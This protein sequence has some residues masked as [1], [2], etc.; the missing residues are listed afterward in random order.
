MK[1]FFFNPNDY[2]PEFSIMA[3]SKEAALLALVNYFL[4]QSKT[5][6]HEYGRES[7]FQDY[8]KWKDATIDSLPDDYSIDE[9]EKDSVVET[10]NG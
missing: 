4:G 9:Y 8:N 7:A 5:D 2:G 6:S 3:D 1:L 10:Y